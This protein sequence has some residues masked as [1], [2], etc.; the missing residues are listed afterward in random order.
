MDK[1]FYCYSCKKECESKVVEKEE[2]L[3]VRGFP[4]TLTVPIRICC[5]C[6]GEDLD[7][8]LDEKTLQRFYDEYEKITGKPV[9]KV[10]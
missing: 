5:V 1:L 2:T 10:P 3:S 9:E 8:D 7:I 6:G 4:I